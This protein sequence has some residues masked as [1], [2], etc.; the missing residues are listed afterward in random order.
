MRIAI[1]DDSSV[2]ANMIRYALSDISSD[3]DMVCFS[4]GRE[5][6][7]AIES[8]D[9]FELA[10]L[11]IYMDG[12]DGISTARRLRELSP[13]TEIIFST[14]S[15]EHAVEAFRVHA[16]DYLVKPYTEMDVV[17]AFTRVNIRRSEKVREKLLFQRGK[18]M[19]VL[20]SADV[21]KLESDRHYTVITL[22]GGKTVSLLMNY[23]NAAGRFQA[24]F[25]ELKRG[26]TVN[27][28]CITE[29]RGT[30][31]VMTDGSVYSIPKGRRDEV[32]REF[33]RFLTGG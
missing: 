4:S 2:D 6:L 24:G 7:S 17:R 3:L 11:D 13:A 10:F 22:S 27:M 15:N 9:R 26:L 14:M 12:E 29:L 31:A 5:L 16:A 30:E 8:G 23:S 19:T 33:T 21:V 20:D 32:I 28:R 1:C 18:T 25:L